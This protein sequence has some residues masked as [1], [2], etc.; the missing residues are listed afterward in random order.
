M[1]ELRR[2]GYDGRGLGQMRAVIAERTS[3]RRC[4]AAL[5]VNADGASEAGRASPYRSLAL[6]PRVAATDSDR[7]VASVAQILLRLSLTGVVFH[8]PAS[9]SAMFQHAK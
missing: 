7:T 5:E 2:T 1:H 3:H 4:V 8:N 9:A 6:S